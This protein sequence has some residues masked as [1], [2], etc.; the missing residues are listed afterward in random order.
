MRGSTKH[1]SRGTDSQDRRR[2]ISVGPIDFEQRREHIRLA[3]SKSIRES[4]V[5]EA[6]QKAAEDEPLPSLP[7]LPSGQIAESH[8]P[9]RSLSEENSQNQS[10]KAANT[11]AL[12]IS[13]SQ[14]AD[15]AS[16]ASQV[17]KD[18]PTLGLP[19]RFPEATPPLSQE[20]IPQSAVSA[21]S[22]STEFDNEPQTTPAVPGQHYSPLDVPRTII[23][24]PSPQVS[25]APYRK[26]EYK[27]PFADEVGM[28][29]EETQVKHN[30]ATSIS[31][32][33]SYQ[34]WS[35][36]APSVTND[37]FEESFNRPPPQP[38]SYETTVTILP[39]QDP[40]ENMPTQLVP[41]VPFPRMLQQDESDY[42]SEFDNGPEASQNRYHGSEYA[43]TD[44]CTEDT[45]DRDRVERH[46]GE[47]FASRR[48]STCASSDV[49]ALQDHAYDQPFATATTSGLGIPPYSQQGKRSSHQSAWTDYSVETSDGA[50][51]T[52]SPFARSQHQLPEVDTGEGFSV[53]YLSPRR[54]PVPSHLPSPDHEPPPIPASASG[55]AYN[56]R[57]SSAYYDQSY[58]STLLN[59]ERESDDYASYNDTPRSVDTPSFEAGEQDSLERNSADADGKSLIADGD[60]PTGKER[61]RLVQRRNVIREL[62]DT[63]AVFVRDMNIVEEIYKGTAEACPKLDDQT[64]KIVFRNSHEIIEFHTSFLAELK[65][66][67]AGV[68]VPKGGRT[69]KAKQAFTTAESDVP[70]D[71]LSDTKDRETAIGEVFQRNIE[72]MKTVHENFL[73]NSD[74]AAKRLIQIQQDS[75]VKVWLT[76]CNE[77]AKDLTAAWDL[78]SLLIKPM[79]RI[80]KYPNI[81]IT[82]LQHTPQHHPDREE[83]IKAKD[84]LETAIIEINKTKKNFELVG[85]IVGRKRKESDVKGG[86]ARAFGKRVDK[87]QTSGARPIDDAAYTKLKEKFGDDYLRLQVVLR[88]VE[89]YTRQVS[90]YVHE[91]LQYLSSIELVM[92]LQPGSY[93]EL[94]SKWVQ[95]N[96]SMRDL[97][98][99]VLEDH[100]AHVRKQVI[101]PFEQVIKA[102][103]NPSLAMKKRQKRRADFEKAEQLRRGGKSLDP[104][105]RELVEQ[106]DALNDALLKE[107]PK[108][109]ALTERVGNICL[110]NF[111]NIQANWY[112]IWK[113][114]MKTVLIDC[115]EMPE[116]QDIVSAFQQDHPYAAD[117]L[118]NIGILNPASRGRP[119]QS[120]TNSI[121]EG[122][123]YMRSRTADPDRRGRGLSMNNDTASSSD[124][125]PRNSDSIS[126]TPSYNASLT[127]AGSSGN[128]PS[129]H[130]YYYR[131]Y[132][133]GIQ[134]YAGSSASPKSS[135]VGAASSK[136]LAGTGHTSTRPSTSRSYDSGGIPRHSSE[137][138]RYK[139]DS[140]T[141]SANQLPQDTSRFSNL[142]HS[143]LPL[144][145]GPN[146]SQRSSRASS[147]DRG[148]EGDGYNVLWLAASL[149]EFNITTTKHEAGYPYLTYQAG[150]VSLLRSATATLRSTC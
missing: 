144:N 24:P 127:A 145:D 121:D 27:Y 77:V 30:A 91:F 140:N 97:E 25:Q 22:T 68:Y 104:K 138:S 78:D 64:V 62:V 45:D 50:L 131:D 40:T 111:V 149:F 139:R 52:D 32:A 11:P 57:P 122:H 34:G 80:T 74:Q 147:R 79:Q 8:Q 23:E 94:E 66:A 118:A 16:S 1:Q 54:P 5:L 85:Q 92:R 110:G 124:L 123:R 48:A 100:L 51:G 142:F 46:Y 119:S 114:K 70:H 84:I 19:G 21:G 18:S 106:Y 71:E 116:P 82:M 56:S 103:G 102:Y 6:R 132:Y 43:T 28:I 120:A 126:M 67:V 42:C 86:L 31:E 136:S 47:E 133:S 93:P 41:P 38:E 13:T 39:P 36:A 125:T 2:K 150:E 73:R 53:P 87:L 69:A 105:L 29:N 148:Q 60:E 146:E 12:T 4:Q 134:Q 14:A 88:D 9:V 115:P 95:F 129:P 58:N 26:S 99:V 49:G 101:E 59:S 72:K 33:I 96:I 7:S 112:R 37:D 141:Y 89:F 20:E 10:G 143:A 76:E 98:K 108:L 81:I 61:Q 128:A 107:L 90:E 55:S 3:Y 113:E 109:S 135:E 44:A 35:S 65:V 117:Q 63:E 17:L 137:S 75:T 15:S 83:L 130:Q